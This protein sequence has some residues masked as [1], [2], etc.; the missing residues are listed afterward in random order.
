MENRYPPSKKQLAF[1]K[2]IESTMPHRKFT[3]QYSDEAYKFIGDA[4]PEI[5]ARAAMEQGMKFLG[6]LQENMFK[7]VYEFDPATGEHYEVCGAFGEEDGDREL[8][9][10]IMGHR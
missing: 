8:F 1:I 4:I 9:N 10:E 5:Q 7:P 3:G 2:D 6:G